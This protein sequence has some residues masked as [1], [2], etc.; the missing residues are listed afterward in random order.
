VELR[1]N[2]V[3][4][5]LRATKDLDLGLAGDRAARLSAF[6]AALR[7]G[8]DEF[9]FR[10][11][12][13]VLNMELADTVRIEVAIN[14]RTRGWQTVDVDLGPAGACVFI[15]RGTISSWQRS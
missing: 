12:P 9:T 5:A 10:M 8:F 11:K 15:V 14:Y 6:E 2:F 4:R 7:L 3:L 13:Q 1:W